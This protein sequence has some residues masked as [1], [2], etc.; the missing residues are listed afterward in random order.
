M[1]KLNIKKYALL[2]IILL[3]AGV[4]RTY[5]YWSVPLSDETADEVAWTWLG[6]SLINDG[7]PTS[8]SFFEAYRDGY[9]YKEGIV[10]AP[11]VRPALDH[12]PLF[13]L[14]PGTM[15]T[16][17]AGQDW[18]T[19]PSRKVI[20][21][22]M[23][24]LGVLNVALLYF[25]TRK[26][27]AKNWSLVAA[28]L[29]A[30]A[31]VFVLSSRLV[32]AENLLVTWS[33]LLLL[34]LMA[35]M[36][37]TEHK[38]R[39]GLAIIA[40]SVLAVMTKLT[41]VALPLSLLAF[42]FLIRD[43][44]LI[45]LGLLSIGGS[46]LA[47]LAYFGIYNLPLFLELQAAQ[48]GR[49]LGLSTLYNRF[50]AHPTIAQLIYFDGWLFVGLFAFI[51]KLI[52]TNFSPTAKDHAWKFALLFGVITMGLIT[53]SSGQY[54]YHGWYSYTLFPFFTLATTVVL[55]KIWEGN[56]LL[57]GMI[58]LLLTINFKNTFDQVDHNYVLSNSLI[59]LTYLLGFTPIIAQVLGRE[60]LAKY[61]C[62][63]LAVILLMSGVITVMSA[64]EI[65][66]RTNNNAFFY[67]QQQ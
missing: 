56:Y 5:N 39:W 31:P 11:I 16:L 66:L 7:T 22:P 1:I 19:I 29:Y 54:T 58:W 15:Q 6:A 26:F 47:I 23:V 17:A 53:V 27:F 42:G 3:T 51:S 63:V 45:R 2:V 14:I 9:I 28:T 62:A 10:N 35:W 20:R 40:V 59:R 49:D 55:K 13:A 52:N 64:N 12:P 41:G 36:E 30:T 21:L 65:A 67:Y 38:Q 57:G 33:L 61:L 60:K 32:V 18:L 34:A 37:N 48:A 25:A 46:A 43:N 4:L 8:W 50:F 24:F 44:K